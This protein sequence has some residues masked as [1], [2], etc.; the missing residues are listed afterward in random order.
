MGMSTPLSRR[1]GAFR[2]LDRETFRLLDPG[3]LRRMLRSGV[4]EFRRIPGRVAA[5]TAA[6][7]AVAAAAA[8]VAC[9]PSGLSLSITNCCKEEEWTMRYGRYEVRE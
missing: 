2:L 3:P 9:A 4:E 8:A 7:E 5:V 6:A 1:R